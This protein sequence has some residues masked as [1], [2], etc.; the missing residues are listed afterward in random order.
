MSADYCRPLG[1][2]LALAL[3]LAG[4]AGAQAPAGPPSAQAPPG[5]AAAP[6]PVPEIVRRADETASRLRA[7]EEAARA[8]TDLSGIERRLPALDEDLRARA[9]TTTRTLADKPRGSILDNLANPFLTAR[10]LLTGWTEQLTRLATEV[11]GD[12]GELASLQATWQATRAEARRTAAPA[13][14]LARVDATLAA[15]AAT[16]SAIKSRRAEVLQL[17]ERVS[18]QTAAVEAA[19]AHIAKTRAEVE[20]PLRVRDGAPLWEMGS[21]VDTLGEV[22]ARAR[23]WIATDRAALRDFLQQHQG[24]I[25]LHVLIWIGLAVGFSLLLRQAHKRSAEDPTL[26]EGVRIFEFPL[27]AALLVAL[28]F[29]PWLYGDLPRVVRAVVGLIGLIPVLR[30]VTALS[31]PPLRPSF[32]GLG[33]FYVLEQ[34]DDIAEVVPLFDQLVFLGE[35]LVAIAYLAWVLSRR[36]DVV[37]APR[38]PA[39]FR[40]L[41]LGMLGAMVVAF[42]LDAIGYVRLGRLL[43]SGALAFAVSLALGSSQPALSRTRQAS[44][45]PRFST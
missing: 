33:A 18:Q 16:E 4:P 41:A 10:S 35:M 45:S 17:Q 20:R 22:P 42:V 2:A 8:R 12:L 28:F 5:P 30:I 3:C 15:I 39:L 25:P 13:A 14:V 1:V 23:E 7:L 19:L 43:G 40:T 34:L 31:E 32:V 36:W 38:R 11:E 6:I 37:A 9:Q 21:A 26:A 24:V 44:A 29:T 27:S